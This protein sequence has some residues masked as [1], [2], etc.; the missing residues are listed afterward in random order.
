MGRRF[1]I[2]KS[3]KDDGTFS[4]DVGVISYGKDPGIPLSVKRDGSLLSISSNDSHVDEDSII[5]RLKLMLRDCENNPVCVV[6]D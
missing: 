3:V 6:K 2:V 5:M 1:G 4:F